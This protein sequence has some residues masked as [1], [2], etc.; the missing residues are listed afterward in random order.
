MDGLARTEAHSIALAKALASSFVIRGA[1][2]SIT[3]RLDSKFVVDIHA[4][5]VSWI[6]KRIA[7]YEN[8]KNKKMKAKAI[9]FFRVLYP[10]LLTIE[11]REAK[12]M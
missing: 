11:R 6:M 2:L 4:K 7:G 3:R 9:E 1:H 10:L 8:N 12:E 5:S